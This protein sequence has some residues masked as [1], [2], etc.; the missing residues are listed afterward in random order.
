M[1]EAEV[2]VRSRTRAG[3]IRSLDAVTK[4]LESQ[5]QAARAVAIAE[6]FVTDPEAA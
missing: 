5:N 2:V 1:Y 4:V 3:L 6:S